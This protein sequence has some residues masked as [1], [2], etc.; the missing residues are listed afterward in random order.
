MAV[1]ADPTTNARIAVQLAADLRSFGVV[2]TAYLIPTTESLSDLLTQ[3]KTDGNFLGAFVAM[4]P[5]VTT[6]S[7]SYFVLTRSWARVAF[8]VAVI[9]C[10]HGAAPGSSN[11]SVTWISNVNDGIRNRTSVSLLPIASL[12]S[13]YAILAPSK[14]S[15]VVTNR[16]F[17]A[18]SP[19]PAGGATTSTATT[20]ST[21]TNPSGSASLI[22]ALVDTYGGQQAASLSIGAQA[23]TD[24]QTSAAIEAASEDFAQTAQTICNW[25]NNNLKLPEK[26]ANGRDIP[27]LPATHAS[28][29]SFARVAPR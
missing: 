24:T 25:S 28:F 21:V 17:P 16:A 5:S 13:I 22:G 2:W 19:Y 10:N 26:L 7:E 29:C 20:N 23:N 18:P 1:G 6:G 4:P 11:P 3:C 27:V 14:T 12:A 15:T 9:E 8:S